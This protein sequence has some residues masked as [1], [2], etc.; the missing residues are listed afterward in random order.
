MTTPDY[1]YALQNLIASIDRIAGG[2]GPSGLPHNWDALARARTLLD[3]PDQPA[4]FECETCSGLG[5]IDERLGGYSFSNPSATCPDCDGM[6]EWQSS[7]TPTV[8]T[9]ELLKWRTESY[10]EGSLDAIDVLI[11]V[12][13]IN[14]FSQLLFRIA[15]VWT[16][17]RIRREVH[18][19][20]SVLKG[21]QP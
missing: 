15:P 17:R 8:S 16:L 5:T 3:H 20:G 6:G 14:F 9:N 21:I 18:K 4:V 7:A 12:I 19:T 1:R 2:P 13:T 10:T 11:E